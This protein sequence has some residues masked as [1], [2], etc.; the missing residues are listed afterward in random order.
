MLIKT[1]K[2]TIPVPE[3]QEVS[4]MVSS[5]QD[6]SYSQKQVKLTDSLVPTVLYSGY[7]MDLTHSGK[8]VAT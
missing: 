8:I 6:G 4:V 7:V 3:V 1:I 2:S 5:R